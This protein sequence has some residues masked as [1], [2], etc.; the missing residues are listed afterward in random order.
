MD[1]GSLTDQELET[2][3]LEALSMLD[4][5]QLSAVVTVLR[6]ISPEPLSGESM[7]SPRAAPA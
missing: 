2:A 6:G 1:L 7:L 5:D 4:Y 3:F